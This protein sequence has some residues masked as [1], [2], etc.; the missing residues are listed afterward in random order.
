MSNPFLGEIRMVGFYF[1]PRGW[2]FCAGQSL[3]ISQNDALYALVGTIYGGDGV[4]T[5]RLPDLRGRVPVSQGQ[6]LGLSSYTI[7]QAA[8]TESVTLLVTQIPSHSHAIAAASG[9]TRSANPSGNLLGSGESDMYTH[10]GANP[11]TL[12]ANTIG[13]NGGSQPHANMQPYL[14]VNFIIALEGV[15]PSRN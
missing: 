7:G 2:A 13:V 10:D 1:A 8:G 5:F 4:T 12:S 15:F 11:A 3:S 6:G 14:S 9:G